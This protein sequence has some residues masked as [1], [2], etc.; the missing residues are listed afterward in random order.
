MLT[1]C[2]CSS[3]DRAVASDAMCAGSTPVRRTSAERARAIR[4][5]ARKLAY[6]LWDDSLLSRKS[7]CTQC[8]FL[9]SSRSAVYAAA[10]KL[11]YSLWDGSLLPR[12]LHCI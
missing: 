1:I 3:V 5:A 8:D 9:F 2:A 4:A 6:F 12:K 11:A 10:R 7:H